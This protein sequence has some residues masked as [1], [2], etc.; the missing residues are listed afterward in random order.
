M[1]RPITV[2]AVD[3]GSN[4]FHMLVVRLENGH[5]RV[6]DRIKESV[7]L[8]GGLGEDGQLDEPTQARALD[9]LARFGQRLRQFDEAQV[10]AVGT[11][12]L[13]QARGAG[14]FLARGEAALGHPIEIIYGVEEA[15]LIYAGVVED[16]EARDEQRLVVDIGGGSTE[17]VIGR[18]EEVLEAESVALGAVTHTQRFFPDGKINKT[19]W[20]AAVTEARLALEPLAYRYRERGWSIAIG[21]SG[22]IKSILRAAGADEPGGVITPEAL[23]R[24]SRAAR[25]AGSIAK[26]SLPGVSDDRQAIFAG[27][28]AV[29]T[30]VFDSLDVAEM[31]VSDKA[32]REGVIH[33][34]LDRLAAHDVREHGIA[35]AARR[36]V[37][38]AEHGRRVADT[39]TRLWLSG[40][41]G[42][43]SEDD[44][45]DHAMAEARRGLRWAAMLHELGLAVA[46]RGYH[47]HGEYLLSNADI[48]GFSQADQKLLATFVRLH[49][50]RLRTE[51][52]DVLPPAW[53]A[54]ARRIVLA[55]RLAVILH[56]GRDPR[57]RPPASLD[58]GD[59]GVTL[60]I[61]G[62]W[63]EARPLTRTDLEREA[64]RL[65]KAGLTLALITE[66]DC[67]TGTG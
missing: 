3:L 62:D 39:A 48:R 64:E 5:R 34:L 30:G 4:S 28:L 33:D 6:V 32:L 11:N 43:D 37:I 19:A 24:L 38:D 23:A 12:T 40:H 63:L 22:S 2:A 53:Q 41:P 17:L 54:R 18:G 29:L 45:A 58:Y 15:R 13:R 31:R 67:A 21:A 1:T 52:I 55:L 50:G 57:T 7:R 36:F 42:L 25:K 20:K 10:R 27:G 66:A 44:I 49:R 65:D 51:L 61:D 60:Y 8:A 56:R 16:F 14:D 26:L 46:H 9:C 59:N 35:D 47:K